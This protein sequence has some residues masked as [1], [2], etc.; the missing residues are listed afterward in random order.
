MAVIDD[1]NIRMCTHLQR[2]PSREYIGLTTR[3]GFPRYECLNC[4]IRGT[5]KPHQADMYLGD[6]YT[7]NLSYA[8]Q[9]RV[10]AAMNEA[11]ASVSKN[12]LK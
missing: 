2:N 1:Q 7:D 5:R 11:L 9:L 10:R 4:F 3:S 6:I 8:S 12:T